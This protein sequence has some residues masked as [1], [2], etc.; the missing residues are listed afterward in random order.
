MGNMLLVSIFRNRLLTLSGRWLCILIF[1]LLMN[2]ETEFWLLY[3]KM[4]WQAQNMTSI[5]ACSWLHLVVK[6]KLKQIWYSRLI[7]T[8]H[9]CVDYSDRHIY[10][11]HMS[12]EDINYLLSSEISFHS[13]CLMSELNMYIQPT[14]NENFLVFFWLFIN[15]ILFCLT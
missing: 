5:Q 9:C 12:Q 10:F 15:R 13:L 11:T 4:W 14:N 3:S 2:S 7:F 8:L 1:V 6:C